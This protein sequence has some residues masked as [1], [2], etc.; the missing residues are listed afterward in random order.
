MHTCICACVRRP[1]ARIGVMGGDQAAHVLAQ[2]EGDKRARSLRGGSKGR[3]SEPGG[4]QQHARGSEGGGGG[5]SGSAGGGSAGGGGGAGGWG[6]GEEAAFRKRVADKYDAEASPWWVRWR[7]RGCIHAVCTL[8]RAR[9]RAC[10]AHPPV[11]W[12]V[13]G[14]VPSVVCLWRG[15]AGAALPRTVLAAASARG[16]RRR[17]GQAVGWRCVHGRAWCRVCRRFASARL[18]D[19]GVIDPADTRR[20]LGLALGAAMHG[21]APPPPQQQQRFGVFRM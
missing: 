7:V 4:G 20:V 16:A 15:G 2:V 6:E 18:W 21:A 11:P 13:Q 5:G 12:C 8:V 14:C 19:D 3:G 17:H 10:G 1:N 9:L